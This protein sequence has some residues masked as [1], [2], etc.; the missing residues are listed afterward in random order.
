MKTLRLMMIVAAAGMLASCA[1]TVP[2]ELA[3]AREAYRRASVGPASRLA[4]V[5]VHAAQLA[6]AEAEKEFKRQPRSYRTLDLAYVAQRKAQLATATATI[7]MQQDRQARAKDDYEKVQGD[8]MAQSKEDLA[9]SKENLQKSES[10]LQTSRQSI[11]ISRER[12]VAEQEARAVSDERAAAAQAALIKMAAVRED[13]RGLVITLS[14][15]VLFVS[16]EDVLQ[17]RARE[18][19]DQVADVLL[20]SPGRN[21]IIEGHTDSQGSESSNE[22]L[23]QRRAEA[24][25][26]YLVQ[27]GCPPERITSRGLGERR[28]I[29]D[30]ASPDGRA[31]NRRVEIVVERGSQQSSNR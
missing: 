5:E 23:S 25:R 11:A 12:L 9:Q 14:G 30:N 17:P 3:N 29:A 22:Q 13:E 19:L 27:K 10:A 18:R 21:I 4:P 24:V 26:A 16:N 6:L 20:A 31:N 2:P 8:V 15:S 1:A 7:A 28:P